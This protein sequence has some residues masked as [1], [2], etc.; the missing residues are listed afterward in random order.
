MGKDGGQEDRFMTTVA[1]KQ[2]MNYLLWK[3]WIK[4]LDLYLLMEPCS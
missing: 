3:L 4:S 1:L 2:T